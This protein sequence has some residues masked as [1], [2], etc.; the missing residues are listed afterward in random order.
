[1]K[2]FVT[3]TT[4]NGAKLKVNMDHIQSAGPHIEGG[5]FVNINGTP[6]RVKEDVSDL[7]VHREQV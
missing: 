5:S 1:M 2:T 7:F 6:I 3:L 4:Q